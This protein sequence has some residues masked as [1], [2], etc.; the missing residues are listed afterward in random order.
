M[1]DYWRDGRPLGVP[2]STK[3]ARNDLGIAGGREISGYLP[4]MAGRSYLHESNQPGAL[5]SHGRNGLALYS[6]GGLTSSE[7]NNLG[8]SLGTRLGSNTGYLSGSPILDS[9]LMSQ[10]QG[11]ASLDPGFGGKSG[12]S[13]SYQRPDTQALRD[14]PRRPDDLLPPDASNTLFVEG[15]PTD[16]TRREAAH[17]FRPFIG[18]KE[19]RLVQKEPKRPGGDPLVLCFV[20]FADARCAATALEALQVLWSDCFSGWYGSA[21]SQI[22]IKSIEEC[23]TEQHVTVLVCI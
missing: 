12:G 7:I 18:F 19:V 10:R 5:D 6:S 4:E 20:D 8:G 23:I 13:L 2:V 21:S 11:I 17:V 14:P 3:R 1:G 22:C 15:L 9:V 16:C